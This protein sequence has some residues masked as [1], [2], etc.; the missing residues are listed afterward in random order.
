M[1]RVATEKLPSCPL[2]PTR[3]ECELYSPA[4][5]TLPPPG[6]GALGFTECERS[7]YS[8][9]KRVVSFRV[10]MLV[11]CKHPCRKM[12]RSWFACRRDLLCKSSSA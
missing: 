1:S 12:R 7:L 8:V 2:G 11:C 4:A 6:I 10:C 5:V 3:L 9:P